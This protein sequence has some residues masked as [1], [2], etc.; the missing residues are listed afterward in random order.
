MDK[1]TR[2]FIGCGILV[3]FVSCGLSR[4]VSTDDPSNPDLKDKFLAFQLTT[5]PEYL[6]PGFATGVP[7]THALLSLFSGLVQYPQKD[8]PV[9]P[10]M[11]TGWEISED[12]K[13][14][15]F[16]I[17]EEARW[18]DGR[19]V[20]AHDFVY[21]WERVLNPSSGAKYAFAM[22]PIRNARDYNAGKIKDPARLGFRA[23]DDRTLQI[24]LESPTPYFLDLLW[25][26]AF[27]PVPRWAVEQ[28]GPRWTRPENIVSNGPFRMKS[29]TPYQEI[30]LVKNGD[31][32]NAAN[33]KLP[34]IVFNPVE[35]KET[36][37]KLFEQGKLD[38]LV[39]PPVMKAA[40]LIRRP[41][42]VQ[43]PF[44]GSYFYR[45]QTSRPPLNDVRVRQALSLS[46]NRDEIVNRYLQGTMIPTH[47]IIPEGIKD[48]R[49][50][51][52][53]GFDPERAK[54]LL[55]EAGYAD[56]STF[57]KVTIHYNTDD[58]HK[59]IAQV[60]Q[61]MWKKYLGIGVELW[62]EEW[63]SYMKT[64]NMKDFQ[65]SRSGWIADYPDPMTFLDMWTSDST[66]SHTG[67]KNEEYDGLIRRAT[68][69]SDQ[70]KRFALLQKAEQIL[71]EEASV[72]PI[73]IYTK[74]YALKPYVK[75]Y[76]PNLQDVHRL[77]AVYLESAKTAAGGDLAGQD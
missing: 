1:I 52:G 6:D 61:Q 56:P 63:K 21:S 37:L 19:P 7:E 74:I 72:I 44:L 34:G 33:V 69:E 30:T 67:W 77:D 13:T 51:A 76:F 35:E 62:N 73:Y 46:V 29:W 42:Y 53:L 36:A 71:I 50:A 18:T 41:G 17:R 60:I 70:R 9:T 59:L 64:Q 54:K 11:A 57:P 47:S 23:L 10:E 12:K 20:T 25:Y 27:K 22:Y 45:I 3:A 28:H 48:Y 14:Y 49:P 2:F 58:R 65:I 16:P 24:T 26:T 15:T 40:T 4:K 43:T 39:E 38:V 68:R 32:Y 8:G 75:G 55:A 31:Y 5:E 66:M